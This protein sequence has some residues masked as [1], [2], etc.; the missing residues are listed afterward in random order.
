MISF[1][2]LSSLYF[3]ITSELGE[4]G[5]NAVEII[6]GGALDGPP[7]VEDG[8]ADLSIC[9]LALPSH[10]RPEVHVGENAGLHAQVGLVPSVVL[11]TELSVL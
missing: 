1:S 6:F 5:N 10:R 11:H 7:E 9:L 3:I 4:K 8:P 2:T